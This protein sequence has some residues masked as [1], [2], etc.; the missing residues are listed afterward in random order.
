MRRIWTHFLPLL[1]V[2]LIVLAASASASAGRMITVSSGIHIYLNNQ[3]MNPTDAYGND[4]EVFTYNGT[5]YLPVRAVGEALGLTVAWDGAAQSVYMTRG[6]ES[7]CIGDDSF[8]AVITDSTKNIFIQPGIRVYLD[9][10]LL[11]PKDANGKPVDVFLYNGTT[12]LP[13]RAISEA[14]GLTVTWDAPSK[15]VLI[16]QPGTAPALPSSTVPSGY[17]HP[18][19]V[20]HDMIFGVWELECSNWT[21][22]SKTAQG[23]WAWFTFRPD[24][25]VDFL[26]QNLSLTGTYVLKPQVLV[27]GEPCA[28]AYF[29]DRVC[30]ITLFQM[31]MDVYNLPEIQYEVWVGDHRNSGVMTIWSFT[32]YSDTEMFGG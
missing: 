32:Q 16:N 10:Q 4:V 20:S 21:Q 29:G 8:R 25:T 12:Y 14:L 2:T 5:T 6:A 28:I 3:R 9:G 7:P 22:D 18:S 24:G 30:E 31:C 15:S 11:E 19:T 23:D 17:V 13:V 27:E 26:S 1:M